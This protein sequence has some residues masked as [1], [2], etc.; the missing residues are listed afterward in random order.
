M[1]QLLEIRYVLA[2]CTLKIFTKLESNLRAG[3]GVFFSFLFH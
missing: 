1:F 3:S 2:F